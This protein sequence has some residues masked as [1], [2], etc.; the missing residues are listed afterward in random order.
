MTYIITIIYLYLSFVSSSSIFFL[1]TMFIS[2]RIIAFYGD[3]DP[4][5]AAHPRFD[6]GGLHTRDSTWEGCTPESK[7]IVIFVLPAQH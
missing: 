3:S 7:T 5:R 4:G 2:A 1:E 6:P